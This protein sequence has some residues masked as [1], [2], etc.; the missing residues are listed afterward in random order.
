[1][2]MTAEKVVK[3]P[4]MGES[5]TEGTLTQWHKRIYILLYYFGFKLR[6]KRTKL[7]WMKRGGRIRQ[8]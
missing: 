5:I 6:L 8:A 2:E 4:S 7:E 1:M 3:T